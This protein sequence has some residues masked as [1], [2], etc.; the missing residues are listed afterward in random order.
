MF[1][2]S[3]WDGPATYRSIRRIL[4]ALEHAQHDDWYVSLG[5][6]LPNDQGL[7]IGAEVRP[8]PSPAHEAIWTAA[9]R[10]CSDEEYVAA[11]RTHQ[12]D[13]RVDPWLTHV[14]AFLAGMRRIPLGLDGRAVLDPGATLIGGL[15]WHTVWAWDSR[16][17]RF[18]DPQDPTQLCVVA[19]GWHQLATD[20]VTLPPGQS[21]GTWI[22]E[23][24]RTHE[25]A[26]IQHPR[27]ESSLEAVL[28]MLTTLLVAMCYSGAGYLDELP[29]AEAGHA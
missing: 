26:I 28:R 16:R 21:L 20:L 29:T 10:G 13:L 22:W 15:T 1:L 11:L 3:L 24:V 7:L 25:R 9:R 4:P 27:S 19:P 5:Q 17:D 14:I 23:W 18:Y 2:Q 6:P 12:V 8:W